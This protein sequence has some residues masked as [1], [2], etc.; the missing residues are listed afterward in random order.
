MKPIA[1]HVCC[2]PCASACLPRLRESA[3]EPVMVFANS[4]LDTRGEYELRLREA[5]RLA[6]A[7]GVRLVALP[8]AHE[9]WL[10][11]VAAGFEGEPEKGARC[12]RCFRYSLRQVAEAAAALGIADFTTSLTISPHKV[13]PI[14]FAAGRAAAA[15]AGGASAF[16]ECDFKKREGFKMS[17]KRSAELG[18]Y[19]QGYCGCEFSRRG[20]SATDA[21]A[22]ATAATDSNWRIHRYDCVDSTNR[23]AAA[24]APGEVFVAAEQSAG[25]G[26]LDHRWEGERGASLLM[27]AVVD[28]AGVKIDEVATLPL[29]AGLAVQA[30]CGG[31]IKWPNDV[32]VKGRKIAGV[33]CERHG[34]CVIVGIGLNVRQSDFP[35]EIRARATSLKLEGIELSVDDALTK[36]LA[37]LAIELGEWRRRGFAAVLPRLNAL[38]CLKGREIAV[39]ARDGD[40][41][42]IRGVCDGIAADGSLLV[43]GQSVYAGEAH[44]LGNAATR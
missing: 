3:R 6:A 40:T 17:L 44:V 2:G 34:D 16:V 41:E 31:E 9:D 32:L 38:N 33:L 13:S 19:R 18:L 10:R 1:L 43:G 25:R 36:L 39:L 26:R 29:V 12:E 35:P 8:Y 42:P 7:E 5:R 24:G 27:S 20:R 14:V 22:G 15:D 37:A 30:V 23:L 4:N 28:V 11:E 21:G